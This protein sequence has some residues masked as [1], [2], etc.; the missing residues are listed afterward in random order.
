[1]KRMNSLA[2]EHGVENGV[3]PYLTLAFMALP[4]IPEIKITARGLFDY[5]SF[6]FIDLFSK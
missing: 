1:M 4:V 5:S 3:D 2:R 6:S